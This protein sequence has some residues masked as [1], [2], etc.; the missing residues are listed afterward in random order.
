MESITLGNWQMNIGEVKKVDREI[1]RALEKF[2]TKEWKEAVL[3]GIDRPW[4]GV[5]NLGIPS[6][7]IRV[8]MAPTDEVSIKNYIYEVEVRPGGLG[9]MLYLMPDRVKQ[10]KSILSSCQGFVSINSSI[11]DDK[12]AADILGMFY[13]EEVPQEIKGAYWVRSNDRNKFTYLEDFSLVPIRQDG[14][15]NYLV[16]LGMA[17]MAKIDKID[18]SKPFV[19]KPLVGSRTE[20]VEIYVPGFL[21]K[22]FGSAG[23]S[24]MSRVKR[25]ISNG[26]YLVQRFIPPHREEIDGKKGWT[27]WRIYFG[28]QNN[29][30]FIGGLWNWRPS[31]RIHGASDTVMGIIEAK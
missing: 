22:E 5:K 18:W 1:I 29:Y 7:I 19:V 26:E 11:K 27:I 16:K 8:D 15:K 12:I 28:W 25:V 23:V 30:K 13:Y 24:T 2:F 21:R 6:P 3:E 4:W 9:I 10:W 17:E 31:L 20:G 14:D